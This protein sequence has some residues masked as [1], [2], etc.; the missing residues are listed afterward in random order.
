MYVSIFLLWLVV[1]PTEVPT[2]IFHPAMWE[3]QQWHEQYEML[4]SLHW[5]IL[6]LFLDLVNRRPA[7][8]L[9]FTSKR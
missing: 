8:F 5:T 6:I 2:H 9:W 7:V 3:I 4:D 1:C